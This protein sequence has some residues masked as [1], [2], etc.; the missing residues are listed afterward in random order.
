MKILKI[1]LICLAIVGIGFVSFKV[2]KTMIKN[3]NSSYVQEKPVTKEKTKKENTNNYDEDVDTI[4][5]QSLEGDAETTLPV[6]YNGNYTIYNKKLY[7][8]N[9][10]SKTWLKVPDN[11]ILGYAN[12]NQYLD[13]IS[14]S[15]IYISNDK[16]AVIYGGRGSENISVISRDS[17]MGGE[18]SLGSISKTATHDLKKGYDKM[19]IDF[20]G[21]GKSG[22]VLVISKKGT[23]N[24]KI[25]VY[26]TV[27]TGVTWDVVSTR[28][29]FYNEALKHFGL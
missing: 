9:N 3:L 25:L 4:A 6:K 15:N 11:N 14:E 18:W 28:E 21:D 13:N 8:T 7:V 27:N 12:V 2:S 16:I 19:Y 23:K 1:A 22:Y 10:K 29:E 5:S 20:L 24:Q 26:R 17:K